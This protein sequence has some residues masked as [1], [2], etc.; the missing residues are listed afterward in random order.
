MVVF[1][2]VGNPVVVLKLEELL[3]VFKL[4]VIEMEDGTDDT[5]LVEPELETVVDVVGDASVLK[6]V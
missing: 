4:V 3:T 1:V 5:R 6:L 2:A